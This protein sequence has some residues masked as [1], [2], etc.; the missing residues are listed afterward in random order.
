MKYLFPK[1]IQYG[2]EVQALSMKEKVFGKE[3]AK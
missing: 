2:I 3:M 1:G